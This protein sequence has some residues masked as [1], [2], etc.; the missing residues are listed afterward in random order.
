MK[1][2]SFGSQIDS[3]HDMSF[4]SLESERHDSGY[5]LEVK[6]CKFSSFCGNRSHLYLLQQPLHTPLANRKIFFQWHSQGLPRWAS[7]PPGGPKWGRK[8]G[9]FEENEES[10]R[11]NKTKWSRFEEKWWK[12]NSCPPGTVRLA[13]A[14]S[15]F[16]IPGQILTWSLSTATTIIWFS[17]THLII[18]DVLRSTLFQGS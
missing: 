16:Q 8:W 17:S 9:K 11:K 14:L 2:I 18:V 10:F 5:N 12:R 13:T 1:I 15:S 4:E 3:N 7:C 6:F